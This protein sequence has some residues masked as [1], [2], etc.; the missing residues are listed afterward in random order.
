[1]NDVAISPDGSLVA[2]ASRYAGVCVWHSDT[3]RLAYRLTGHADGKGAA[4]VT[5]SPDGRMLATGGDD[6]TVRLWDAATGRQLRILRAYRY[7]M[8][9]FVND[10]QVAFTPD[11]TKLV[12]GAHD[13]IVQVWDVATG[14]RMS[15]IPGPAVAP[16][17]AKYAITVMALAVAP[18]GHTIAVADFPNKTIRLL[19]IAPAQRCRSFPANCS[20]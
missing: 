19:D 20:V 4:R 2:S 9:G 15:Q 7:G 11:G 17:F 16:E 18:D 14:K 1:M 10:L 12:T 3:G 8:L 6:W 5:F 13:G